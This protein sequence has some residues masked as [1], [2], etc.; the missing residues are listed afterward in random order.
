LVYNRWGE[1]IFETDD[2]NEGWDGKKN[3]QVVE[4]GTYTWVLFYTVG[5]YENISDRTARGVVVIMK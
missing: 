1:L 2:R 5:L 4:Q 3:G